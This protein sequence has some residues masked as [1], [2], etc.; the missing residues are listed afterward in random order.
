MREKRLA[1]EWARELEALAAR[2]GVFSGGRV[3]DNA[4]TARRFDIL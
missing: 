3:K 4:L 1:A 2:I